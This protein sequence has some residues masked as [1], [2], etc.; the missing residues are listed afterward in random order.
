MD[1]NTNTSRKLNI[2]EAQSQRQTTV[3]PQPAQQRVPF[4]KFEHLLIGVCSLVVLGM[5][6]M[7]VSTKIAVSNGQHK[8]QSIQTQI[9][10]VNSSNISKKEEISYL[11]SQSHLKKTAVQYNL[12]DSNSDVRDV[13]K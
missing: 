10:N 2:R 5:M 8:L 13:T 7:L 12:K 3:A 9:S 6:V 1:Y 4:S 11:S